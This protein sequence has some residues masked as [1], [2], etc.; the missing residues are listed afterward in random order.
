MRP[1]SLGMII[2][3]SEMGEQIRS[4]IRDLPVRLV[5]EEPKITDWEALVERLDRVRPDVVLLELDNV[6]DPLEEVIGKIKRS[7]AAPIVIAVHTATDPESILTAIRAGASEYLYPPLGPNLHKALN[8]IS[9]ER[10]QEIAGAKTGGAVAFFSAKGGCGATTVACHVAVEVQRQ[11]GGH[12]LLADF[13]LDSGI[14]GFIMKSRSQ[15][16]LVDALSNVERLDASYW[17]AL[18][19]NGRP[20]MEILA[21]PAG[22]S[23]REPSDLENL[24]FVLHFARSQYEWV[25]VDLGRGLSPVTMSALEEVDHCF[26]VSSVDVPALYKCKHVVRNL[27]DAGYS[28][29]RLHLVMNRI[30]RNTEITKGEIEQMLGVPVAFQLPDEQASLYE[31]YSAGQLLPATHSLTRRM[32][33]IARLITGIPEEKPSKRRLA[34]FG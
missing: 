13:D 32:G 18:I 7:A 30:P 22:I 1:L 11:C 25:V 31:A 10:S 20:G 3:D 19:S 17:K 5:I 34:F 16:T 14:V 8:R 26:L 6:R 29:D 21:A 9:N 2:A 27:L 23:I 24:R 33:E 12:V 15:Y 28:R 4:C